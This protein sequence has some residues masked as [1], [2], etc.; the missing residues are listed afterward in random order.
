MARQSR[1]RWAIAGVGVAGRARAT[2]IANDPRSVLVAVWRGRHAAEV[3]AP[4]VDSLQEAIDAADCVAVCSPSSAHEEQIE[5]A[6]QAGRH[7]L[8]E[9]PL[10]GSVASATALLELAERQQ[11]VLHVEHI[12]LLGAIPQLLRALVP[13]EVIERVELAFDAPRAGDEATAEMAWANVARL[14]RVVDLAGPVA[15]IA[16]VSHT[17]GHLEAELVLHS[18]VPVSLTFQHA[19][20]L[21]RRTRLRV[22]TPGTVWEQI[23]DTLTR[24]GT[25]QTLLGTGSLF[26]MDQLT[27]TGRILDG[28][29]PYVSNERILHVLR[30]IELLGEASP[31]EV[32][33]PPEPT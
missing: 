18:G 5:A 26:K 14:H 2:A 11:R 32:P 31:A 15:R 1:L 23:N 24:N 28:A 8:V 12:E 22:V 33:P 16:Q 25:P 9:Y 13:R 21:R 17:P 4:A 29:P 27:A 7:V 19:P 3:E 20:H 30:V 6:L 10:A